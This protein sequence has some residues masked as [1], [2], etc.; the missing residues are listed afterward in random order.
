MLPPWRPR[1]PYLPPWKP[2]VPV[3]WNKWL[4]GIPSTDPSE[5]DLTVL[6]NA[7]LAPA[8]DPHHLPG[9]DAVN[10]VYTSLNQKQ[11]PRFLRCPRSQGLSPDIK[12]LPFRVFND[13][14]ETIFGGVLRWN[15]LLCW[16]S[17][18]P[19]RS[20]KTTR[21]EEPSCPRI[22][23]ELSKALLDQGSRQVVLEALLH[24]MVHAYLL[25][26]CSQKVLEAPGV[27]S[28]LA[29]GIRFST[30]CSIILGE[31]IG[32]DQRDYPYPSKL[33]CPL[34]RG[35]TFR[36]DLNPRHL[37]FPPPKPGSTTCDMRYSQQWGY[38]LSMVGKYSRAILNKSSVPP[39]DLL[40][41]V[42]IDA[43]GT[44]RYAIVSVG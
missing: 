9:D 13:I 42:L 16:S 23:I 6:S 32:A 4:D 34:I 20:G 17:L 44:Q 26:F 18:A 27:D 29:H 40:E 12:S 33:G 7:S 5:D 11:D 2:L 31:V 21:W 10:L 3:I 19:G 37:P 36:R 15:V 28:N 38:N 1:R 43:V 35:E 25:Q 39:L 24:Q 22:K 8:R 30:I 41:D 14:D